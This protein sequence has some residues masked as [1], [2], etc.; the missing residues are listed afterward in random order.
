MEP[1]PEVLLSPQKISDR[2]PRIQKILK[3]EQACCYLLPFPGKKVAISSSGNPEDMDPDFSRYLHDF[4]TD[5]CNSTTQHVKR[6]S[7]GHIL[8]GEELAENIKTLF[9][10]LQ[11]KEFGYS[12]SYVSVKSW[13]IVL[14]RMLVLGREPGPVITQIHDSRLI[15]AAK[16]ELEDFVK[17]QDSSTKSMFNCLKTVPRVMWTRLSTKKDTILNHLKENLKSPGKNQIMNKFETQIEKRINDFY[18]SYKKRFCGCT[19]AVGGLVGASLVAVA[20]G[21]VMAVGVAATTLTMEAAAVVT[22]STVG[23]TVA[24]GSIGAGIGAA[25]GMAKGRKKQIPEEGEGKP[26]LGNDEGTLETK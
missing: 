11:T 1:I 7:D 22:G 26:L 13:L 14:E 4:I 3:S 12:S 17:E 5:V 21:G 2:Y 9:N 6:H 19:A 18:K 24:G 8:T 10:L 16:K 23:A 20:T 25:V 15:K